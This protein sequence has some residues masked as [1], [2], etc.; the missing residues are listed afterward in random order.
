MN[1]LIVNDRM[2]MTYDFYLKQ[3]K[4]MFE[5]RLTAILARNPN[6]IKSF[7]RFHIHPLIRKYSYI[8]R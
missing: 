5:W 6:L 4:S 7:N 1:I 3:P 2:F 8:P